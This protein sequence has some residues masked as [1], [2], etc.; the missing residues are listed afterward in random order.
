VGGG[1]PTIS[2]KEWKELGEEKPEGVRP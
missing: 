1:D 2:K